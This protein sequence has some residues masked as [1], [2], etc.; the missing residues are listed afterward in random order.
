LILGASWIAATKGY[1]QEKGKR[2]AAKEDLENILKEVSQTTTISKRIEDNFLNNS[3]RREKRWEL[4][5]EAIKEVN[6]QLADFYSKL[7]DDKAFKPSN[8]WFISFGATNA[9]IKALFDEEVYKQFKNAEKLIGPPSDDNRGREFRFPE[10]HHAA[11]KAMI[12]YVLGQRR[13]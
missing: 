9:L 8:E 10:A 1:Y 3:W 5:I 4:Q 12:E 6:L 13:T 2:L 7:L 11:I